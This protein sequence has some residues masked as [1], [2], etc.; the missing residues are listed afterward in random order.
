MSS[1]RLLKRHSPSNKKFRSQ[2]PKSSK[3]ASLQQKNEPLND[4]KSKFDMNTI[5][6]QTRIKIDPSQKS[7]QSENLLSH[8]SFENHE[9]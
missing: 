2:H 8:N 6:S 5:E 1:F 4:Y 7:I 3:T 9:S